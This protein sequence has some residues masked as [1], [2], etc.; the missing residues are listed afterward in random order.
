VKI[1][2]LAR[3]AVKQKWVDATD[4]YFPPDFLLGFSVDNPLLFLSLFPILASP[5]ESWSS[6]ERVVDPRDKQTKKNT[7]HSLSW[8]HAE[9]R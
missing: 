7:G 2:V 8:G 9:Q 6:L 4:F 1:P 3:L 5:K